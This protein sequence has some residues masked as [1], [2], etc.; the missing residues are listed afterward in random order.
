MK[1]V[2]L[3]RI[4]STPKDLTQ[5]FKDLDLTIVESERDKSFVGIKTYTH[6]QLSTEFSIAIQRCE[7]DPKKLSS[8]LGLRL[9]ESLKQYG[10]TKYS[11]WVE[12]SIDELRIT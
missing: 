12:H 4:C 3:I 11:I 5:L 9:W 10:I 7:D 1:W 6:D 2:E 8:D